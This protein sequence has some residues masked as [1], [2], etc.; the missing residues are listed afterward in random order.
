MKLRCWGVFLVSFCCA[1]CVGEVYASD[2][3]ATSRVKGVLEKAMEIQTRPDLEGDAHRAGRAK[4][5]RQVIAE[6]FLAGQMA[7]ESIKDQWDKITAAQRREF[8]DLF[9]VDRKSTRLNSSH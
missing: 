5:V 4:L 9:T 7:Q 6:N 3:G 1:V 2:G 8:E